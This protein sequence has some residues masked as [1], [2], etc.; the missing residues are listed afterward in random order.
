MPNKLMPSRSDN[1]DRP[2]LFSG[3]SPRVRVI[4][5]TRIKV[6]LHIDILRGSYVGNS[7]RNVRKI[8]KDKMF[9]CKEEYSFIFLCAIVVHVYI[10]CARDRAV[11]VGTVHLTVWP[12]QRILSI[13][14]RII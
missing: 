13:K 11:C 1:S 3:G 2:S 7:S 12:L 9:M 6:A 14:P 10:F 4:V 8:L 5:R